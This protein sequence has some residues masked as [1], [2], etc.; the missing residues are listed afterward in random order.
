MDEPASDRAGQLRQ[1][2]HSQTAK[3][4]W[5]DLQVHYAR[6]AVIAVAKRCD[7][8]D[9]AVQLGLDNTEVFQQWIEQGM[10]AGVT[11]EQAL[12]WY[13]EGAV[14]WTVVAPPWVLVQEVDAVR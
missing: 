3:L 5:T 8:V 6:G 7:L 2:Y 1:E 4:P 10:V 9:V 14:L 11:A 12:K 13:E